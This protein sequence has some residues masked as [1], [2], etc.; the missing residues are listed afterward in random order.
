MP[1]AEKQDVLAHRGLTL[2]RRA[3]RRLDEVG[4]FAQPHVSLEHQHLARRYVVR[5]I[6]S[7]GA[8]KEIGRYVTFCGSDG[9]P[10]A[11]LHAIDSIGVNGVHAVVVAPVLVRIELFRSGRT[12]QLLI[13]RHEPGKVENGR[14]PPV[15]N[16]VLFRGV[17]GFL[18]AEQP[19]EENYLTCSAMPRFWSRA[20]EEREIPPVFVAAVQAATKGARCVGCLHAHYLVSRKP[21]TA[22]PREGLEGI[23][24]EPQYLVDRLG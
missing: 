11:Y 18:D 17:N 4:I 12:C 14:R 2:P 19:G 6:E 20:G 10:L 7:G 8:V 22:K 9:E 23:A 16:S 5:G 21:T 3:L 15:E 1:V 24:Q 13:T